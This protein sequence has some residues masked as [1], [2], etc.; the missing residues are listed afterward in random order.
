MSV[1]E[2]MKE[3]TAEAL[4]L[5]GGDEVQLDHTL[6]E[7]LGAD[8]IDFLDIFFLIEKNMGLKID[9]TRFNLGGLDVQNEEYMLDNK[10]T[11]KGSELL[12]K[13]FP[14]RAERYTEG[15]S[16]FALMRLITVA[17]FIAIVKSKIIFD[18]LILSNAKEKIEI[19]NLM[20][21]NGLTEYG[22]NV[23]E[24]YV[25]ELKGELKMGD[26]S[27]FENL[28]SQDGLTEKGA[29][30]LKRRIPEMESEIQPGLNLEQ[31]V[32]V[33][34]KPEY[35]SLFDKMLEAIKKNAA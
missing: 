9:T 13:A 19:D 17:D 30:I 2:Q 33:F 7:D 35:E 4:G 18:Y 32:A 27:G 8:S 26:T 3:M 22:L 31:W 16:S 5:A 15:T 24:T 29:S 20:D 21:K 10:L 12:Q 1:T 34:M 11:K 6:M 28:I 14:S 23:I 25:P